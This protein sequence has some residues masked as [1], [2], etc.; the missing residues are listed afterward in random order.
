MKKCLR[1]DVELI[2]LGNW[3]LHEA[4]PDSKKI[5][6]E[7]VTANGKESAE[8]IP[9]ICPKC[10]HVELFAEPTSIILRSVRE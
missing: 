10:G 9:C 4:K 1:C 6:L 3:R 2:Y 8:L 5:N 7:F